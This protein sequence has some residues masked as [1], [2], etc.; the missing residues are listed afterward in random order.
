M[1]KNE[2]DLESYVLKAL[3]SMQKLGKTP[4]NILV[5]TSPQNVALIIRSDEEPIRFGDWTAVTL[6]HKDFQILT[7]MC[8]AIMQG[9]K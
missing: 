4:G 1:V 6:T 7:N 3:G 8:V 2:K 5:E 9:K